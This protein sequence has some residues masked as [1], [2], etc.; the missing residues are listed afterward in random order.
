MKPWRL[1]PQ[2][3]NA[4][5]IVETIWEPTLIILHRSASFRS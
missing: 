4:V 5:C 2:A 1:W 3:F